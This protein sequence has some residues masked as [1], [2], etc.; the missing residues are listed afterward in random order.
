M[1]KSSMPSN[2]DPLKPVKLEVNIPG[3]D[4]DYH[5]EVKVEEHSVLVEIKKEVIP[6][7]ALSAI[8]DPFNLDKCKMD[9]KEGESI[10]SELHTEEHLL[11]IET[12][13]ENEP[14][15]TISFS[16][17]SQTISWDSP[18]KHQ[19]T[20]SVVNS[21]QCIHCD[22]YFDCLGDLEVHRK[23]QSDMKPYQC[24][25]CD[26]CY[27]WKCAMVKHLRIHTE[28]KPIQIIYHCYCGKCF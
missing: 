22:K 20:H 10:C 6:K 23:T 4:N 18:G 15:P 12:N 11:Q 2:M 9:T 16:D 26:K 19:R 28:G 3:G 17:Q 5:M 1:N 13:Q 24:G 14:G 7:E 25:H 21:Y 8:T 27:S